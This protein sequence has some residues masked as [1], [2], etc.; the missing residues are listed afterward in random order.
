[1]ADYYRLTNIKVRLNQSDASLDAIINEYGN[2]V[3]AFINQELRAHLGDTNAAGTAIVLPLTGVTDPPLTVDTQ[4][5]ADDLTIAYLRADQNDNKELRDD[6]EK[7]FATHLIREYGYS[8][9]LPFDIS[10]LA[11]VT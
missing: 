5:M 3:D 4:V 6:A 2:Q 7:R 1:M 8:R 10:N 11:D 9:D